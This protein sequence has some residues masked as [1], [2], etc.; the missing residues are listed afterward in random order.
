MLSY[1]GLLA[2]PDVLPFPLFL[3]EIRRLPLISLWPV[4]NLCFEVRIGLV[5]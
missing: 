2:V 4:L 5:H 3:L 1:C